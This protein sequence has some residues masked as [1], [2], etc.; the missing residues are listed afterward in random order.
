MKSLLSGVSIDLIAVDVDVSTVVR[1]HLQ[2]YCLHGT[3]IRTAQREAPP[4]L[5]VCITVP[6]SSVVT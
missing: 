4:V 2:H 1:S 3:Y 6:I 5:I